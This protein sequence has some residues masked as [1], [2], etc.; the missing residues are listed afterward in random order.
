MNANAIQAGLFVIAV[1]LLV[2]PVGAYLERV[3]E[4]RRTLLDPLLL[5]LE[6]LIYRLM[7]IDPKSEM[8]WKGYS[9]AFGVFG[10]VNMILLYLALCWQAFLP[11]FLPK[12]MTTPM[13]PDLAANTA[14]SFATTT[15]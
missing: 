7:G 11:R 10:V 2:K 1:A 6:R 12:V 8:D 5:P 4:R 3:F 13:T 9:L 14:V 15:T